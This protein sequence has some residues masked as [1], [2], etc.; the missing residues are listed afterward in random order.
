[1]VQDSFRAF[2]SYHRGEL[3][4]AMQAAEAHDHSRESQ[5][6][7]KDRACTFYGPFS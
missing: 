2:W 4:I 5:Q 1:M 3:Y 6:T 7:L